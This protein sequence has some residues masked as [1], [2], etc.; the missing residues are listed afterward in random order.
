MA[1]NKWFGTD[2]VRG[3]ANVFPMT[4]DF[5][6][7]LGMAAGQLVCRQ[8]HQ[9]AIAKYTPISGDMLEAALSAGFAAQGVNVVRLGVIPTPA[10]T[11]LTPS[12]DVDMAVMITA[13]HNPYQDNGIKLIAADGS[14]FSDNITAELEALVE[15]NEFTFDSGKIGTAQINNSQLEK[16][17]KIALSVATPEALTGLKIVI[18]C[19][20]GCFSGIMPQVFAE[21][22]ANVIALSCNPDGYNIN[23]DCGSQHTEAMCAKVVENKAD[24]GVAVDGDGDRIIIC[25]EKGKRLDGDQI[26][27]YLG[28]YFKENGKLKNNTVVATIVSNPALDRFLSGLGINCVRSGVGERYVI[29]EMLKVG[30]NIG[31]EESGHMV[32]ADYSKT[33]DAMMAALVV[34]MGIKSDGHKMSEIFP[35]FAPMPRKR[36]DS[37]F[38]SKEQMLKAFETEVFKQA[39]AD[40]EQEV[41]GKGRVLVRKSG[42]EP[43]IQ[44]WVWSDEEDLAAALS[45]KISAPLRQCAGF[46]GAKNV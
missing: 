37:K 42:T 25:D 38:A 35:L 9:V 28:K 31:G 12:L 16:Y 24:L 46:D 5:A 22:G 39:I 40:G 8:K 45:Q 44:V 13:S 3:V 27:A 36:T 7:R 43:K 4:A 29:D 34:A 6:M 32:V 15:K 30:C 41:F 11:T 19:A 26:I 14:K 18:D 33:G 23:R 1:E 17:K 20:N 2:G 21:L 10:L